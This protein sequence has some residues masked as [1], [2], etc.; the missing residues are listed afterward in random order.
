MVA[1][2]VTGCPTVAGLGEAL[3]PVDVAVCCSTKAKPDEVECAKI[4]LPEKAATTV[5]DPAG[6]LLLTSIAI[7]AE[8]SADVPSSVVPL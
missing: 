4:T 1:V 2:R 6:R 8:L 7:P 3:R 5:S